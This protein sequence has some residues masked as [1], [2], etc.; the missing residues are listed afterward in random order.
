M[1]IGKAYIG[2]CLCMCMTN[3]EK[4][5]GRVRTVYRAIKQCEEAGKVANKE[6]VISYMSDYLK[7]SPIKVRQY[8]KELLNSERIKEVGENLMLSNDTS[9]KSFQEVLSLDVKDD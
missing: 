8:V 5:Y 1:S 9:S 3:E 4:R 6:K 2:V 7:I